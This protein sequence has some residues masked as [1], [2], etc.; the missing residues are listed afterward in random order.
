MK[1]VDYFAY[2][3]Y[4]RLNQYYY[5]TFTLYKVLKKNNQN[6]FIHIF[7]TSVF[8]FTQNRWT[9]QAYDAKNSFLE[10]GKE[11]NIIK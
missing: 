2:T 8:I 5:G 10:W 3:F 9:T 11:L 4:S 1:K 6:E 7:K